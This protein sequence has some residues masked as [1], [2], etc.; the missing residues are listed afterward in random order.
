MF[1]GAKILW[2]SYDDL[3]ELILR[4]YA[5]HEL[6]S[7]PDNNWRVVPETARRALQSEARHQTPVA[8]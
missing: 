8:K 7:S 6:P 1:K 4:Y 5:D 2:R 3:R